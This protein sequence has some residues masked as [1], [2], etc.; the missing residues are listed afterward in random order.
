MNNSDLF[1]LTEL[2]YYP[3]DEFKVKLID[4]LMLYDK[5]SDITAG[6]TPDELGYCVELLSA[7]RDPIILKEK[8]RAWLLK[9]SVELENT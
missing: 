8:M 9:K 4:W 3:P 7:F 5:R 6:T 2:L 1:Q